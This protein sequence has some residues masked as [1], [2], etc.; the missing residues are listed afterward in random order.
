MNEEDLLYIL[1]LQRAKGVG[2]INAKKLIAHC[3]SAKNVITTK[4]KLL[5]KIHG[6]GS[7]II[8]NLAD[9]TN[10]KEAEIE[11]NYILKNGIETYYF[12][13][14]KYPEKLKHCLDGPI[15]LFKDGNF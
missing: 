2:D 14:N 7:Y 1:A 5:D 9:F 12:L 4:P 15:L 8:K 11:L 10:L 6:I 13:E 3:G